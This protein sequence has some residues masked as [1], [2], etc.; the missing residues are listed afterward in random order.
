LLKLD[1][2]TSKAAKYACENWHYSKIMP[3]CQTRIGVWED[4][5]FKGVILFGIGAGNSTRGEKYGLA[6]RGEVAELVRV[7]LRD[8]KAPVS[9]MI[10][11]AIKM[12]K[13]RNSGIKLVISFA[14]EMSQ[15]HVGGIYQAGNWIYAGTFEGDDGWIIHGKVLHNKTIHS[16]GWKQTKEWLQKNIDPNVKKNATKKHRYLMPLDKNIKERIMHLSKP[17]PKRVKQAM[18]DDQSEQRQG[19]TD[20]HAPKIEV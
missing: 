14:D 13:R 2:A 20:L 10:A 4:N 15:G 7:A 12:M 18:T 1:W 9:K 6:R 8:H 5:Q 19:S 11:I 3:N 16:K 17:Y